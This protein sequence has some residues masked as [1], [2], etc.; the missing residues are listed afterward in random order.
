ML[1]CPIRG[2]PVCWSLVHIS[3][4]TITDNTSHPPPQQKPPNLK[5]EKMNDFRNITF[6][7]HFSQPLLDTIIK[8][9]VNEFFIDFNLY[10]VSLRKNV[11]P[12][13]STP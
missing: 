2:F 13:G 8:M 4:N 6:D 5:L 10:I 9:F 11:K 1:T 3:Q 12:G 7:S